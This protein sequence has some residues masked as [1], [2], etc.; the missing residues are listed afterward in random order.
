[1]CEAYIYDGIQPIP[2]NAN[3]LNSHTYSSVGLHFN[4]TILLKSAAREKFPCYSSYDKI[5]YYQ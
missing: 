3:A 5:N 2:A 1:M 4:R